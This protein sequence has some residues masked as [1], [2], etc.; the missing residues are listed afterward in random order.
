M[1]GPDWSDCYNAQIAN[2]MRMRMQIENGRFL[3]FWGGVP[4]GSVVRLLFYS[5][6]Y[7][8]WVGYRENNECCGTARWNS[9]LRDKLGFWFWV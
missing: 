3:Y 4:I 2:E 6:M 7:V 8:V 1:L 9:E 5:S